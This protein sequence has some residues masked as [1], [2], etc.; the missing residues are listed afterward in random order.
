MT[1]P[2][3]G[4][5]PGTAQPGTGQQVQG[6]QA[7]WASTQGL[8]GLILG[9]VLIVAFLLWEARAADPMIPLGIFRSTTFSS[10][11]STQ[12]LMSAAI[13]SAAFLTSQFFQFALGN[14]PL[15]TGLRFLPW[16]ATPLF[17]APAA[18]ALSDNTGARNLVVPGL[19]MQGAGFA[20]IVAFASHSSG[21]GGYIAPF[22]IA[23][24][25]FS[26]AVPCVTAAG[27][28]AVS[29]YCSARRREP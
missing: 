29:P 21:Y 6:S 8:T 3:R 28:N 1:A 25:G 12:F 24:T 13:Y 17:V 16:T 19:L 20:W 10:A 14:S 22:I 27:L 18:G 4:A 15:G 11:V 23:G 2:D 5:Q 7:G 9:P 26:M